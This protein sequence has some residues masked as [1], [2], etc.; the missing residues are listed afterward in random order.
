VPSYED[1]DDASC[2]T[3]VDDLW[4]IKKKKKKKKK[5]NEKRLDRAASAL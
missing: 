1:E 2:G 4:S 3:S 5:E